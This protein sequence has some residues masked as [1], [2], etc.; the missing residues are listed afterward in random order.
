MS[1]NIRLAAVSSWRSSNQ[2]ATRARTQRRKASIVQCRALAI[3]K[4]GARGV[5]VAHMLANMTW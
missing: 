1:D 3:S 5:A 4:R 2:R